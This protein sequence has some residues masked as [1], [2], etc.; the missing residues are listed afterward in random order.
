MTCCSCPSWIMKSWWQSTILS[1]YISSSQYINEGAIE[2]NWE[3]SIDRDYSNQ[4]F[5]ES[6]SW[7]LHWLFIK[8]QAQSK[9]FWSCCMV[10]HWVIGGTGLVQNDFSWP[11]TCHQV[12][13]CASWLAWLWE[14]AWLQSFFKLWNTFLA[15]EMSLSFCSHQ[16]YFIRNGYGTCTAIL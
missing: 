8:S 13:Y 10:Q 4:A 5:T 15:K 9:L 11:V 7:L 2:G 16:N 3:T 14:E 1:L 12:S 6:S